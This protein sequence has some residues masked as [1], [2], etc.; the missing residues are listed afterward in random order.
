MRRLLAILLFFILALGAGY[1]GA[2]WWNSRPGPELT[3]VP[4]PPPGGFPLYEIEAE[5]DLPKGIITGTLTLSYR[6]AGPDG[7]SDLVFNLL[8]NILHPAEP[9]LAVLSARVGG[10][11]VQP[12]TELTVLRIPLP[13]PLATGQ[14]VRVRLDFQTRLPPL[15]ARLG[16]HQDVVM[17]GGWYPALAPYRDGEWTVFDPGRGI[18][19]PYY[20]ESANYRVRLLAPRGVDVFGSADEVSTRRSGDRQEWFMQS[21]EPIREFAFT[22]GQFRT[23][24]TK[25]EGVEV[26]YAYPRRPD[27][28]VLDTAA[29][30]LSM[31][32]RLFGPYPYRRLVVAEVPL[33][34]NVGMEY[35]LLVFM[36]SQETFTPFTVAH[37]VAHQWWYGLVGSDQVGEPWVDEGLANFAALLFYEKYYPTQY[38]QLAV[39]FRQRSAGMNN[40]TSPLGVYSDERT[41]RERAYVAAAMSWHGK[42]QR[43][44]A[45]LLDGLREIA[46]RHRHGLITSAEI[47]KILEF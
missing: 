28:R 37:E 8:P 11:P 46:S 25:V 1:G 42:Y 41:Y 31:F 3:R 27:D 39:D 38:N 23:H 17:A 9:P 20:T 15:P 43:D 14:R 13:E 40:F 45:G 21:T 18:G 29:R 47:E 36:S 26:V 22:A 32:Q 7:L 4:S 35:P 6:H 2:A 30:S 5:L 33:R 12:V 44:P 24:S 19:D 10:N 34:G 16:Y